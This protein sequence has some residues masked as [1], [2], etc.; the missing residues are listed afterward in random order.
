ME[1][2]QNA[3]S[4]EIYSKS[5]K[6]ATVTELRQKL[7]WTTLARRKLHAL[8]MAHNCIH[9]IG[10]AY[11]HHKFQYIS[12]L[13]DRQK[14]DHPLANF[15]LADQGQSTI[16]KRLNIQKYWNTLPPSIR[17]LNAPVPF[18]KACNNCVK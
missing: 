12:D 17:M 9:R 5:T 11:L 1:A 3:C 7:E 10:P 2:I 14:G 18:E 16:D 4:A 6:T 15:I 13:R 8:E